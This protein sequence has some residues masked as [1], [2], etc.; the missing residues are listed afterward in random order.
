[1]L[2]YADECALFSENAELKENQIFISLL[3][4]EFGLSYKEKKCLKIIKNKTEF[5]QLKLATK[6]DKSRKLQ[7]QAAAFET[8]EI[9]E[10]FR[11][12]IKRCKTQNSSL[13]DF[14]IVCPT[15]DYVDIIRNYSE[16]T[17]IP[18]EFDC[19]V[20]PKQKRGFELFDKIISLFKNDFKF[21]DFKRF[22]QLSSSSQVNQDSDFLMYSKSALLKQSRKIFAAAGLK[23]NIKLLNN[24]IF[25]QKNKNILEKEDYKLN[26][27]LQLQKILSA[28]DKFSKQYSDSAPIKSHCSFI[29]NISEKFI[30]NGYEKNFILHCIESMNDDYSDNKID[31]EKVYERLN[32]E[33]HSLRA[34]PV[35]KSAGVF[36]TRSLNIPCFDYV[37]TAGL[38]DDHYPKQNFQNPAL[39]DKEK[40]ELNKNYNAHFILTSDKNNYNDATFEKMIS[41]ANIE[42]IGFYSTIDA[43]TGKER[44]P[45]FY[46]IP[47]YEAISKTNKKPIINDKK[48]WDEFLA[49]I[50][51][52]NTLISLDTEN[53]LTEFEYDFGEME[54]NGKKYFQQLLTN[55][56]I[57]RAYSS[58][59]KK[60]EPFFNEYSGII[61]NKNK[62]EEEF[63]SSAT[64]L[65]KFMSCP[66]SFWLERRLRISPLEEPEIIDSLDAL[67]LGTIC[68]ETLAEFMT[69]RIGEKIVESDIKFI[70]QIALKKLDA[71]LEKI[72]LGFE[73][74]YRKATDE[75]KELMQNFIDYE[76]KNE[77]EPYLFEKEFGRENSENP[78]IT[79]NTGSNKIKLSGSIDRVDK[80]KDGYR[81]ID[82]K[83]SKNEKYL[84]EDIIFNNGT[85]LQ[86]YIYAEVLCN[87]LKIKNKKI[88]TGYLALKKTNQNDIYKKEKEYDDE[89]R[90]KL[91]R[92]LD[93]ILESIKNNRFIQTGNCDYCGYAEICGALILKRVERKMENDTSTFVEEYSEIQGWD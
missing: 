42:W 67:T 27:M 33:I 89:I 22:L 80:I 9:K 74:N 60:W 6:K 11:E 91:L 8:I 43:M 19:G 50:K 3:Q 83:T 72:D 12:I 46:Y 63:C 38:N 10:I 26:A 54:N 62:V 29:K 5:I 88:F 4:D 28:Y 40:A 71:V 7:L 82:Y 85:M 39:L 18:C 93:F 77:S 34:Y 52:T 86:P 1:M 35:I 61:E 69:S 79:I 17:G 23:K 32:S 48:Q 16:T 30:N 58:E 37:F 51:K 68:H 76:I 44:I 25:E 20:K 47:V 87:L 45:S 13:A 81:I 2:D 66:Y 73:I 64:A 78:M 65:E 70:T 57:N 59:L 21:C 56:P 31:F 92:I 41:A 24:A 53:A 14:C 49:N 75:I 55:K 90:N 15:D 84:K 36:V